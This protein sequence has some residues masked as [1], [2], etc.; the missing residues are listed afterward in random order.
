MM[1]GE[2]AASIVGVVGSLLGVALSYWI[3]RD[4]R[5][6]AADEVAHEDLGNLPHPRGRA[7]LR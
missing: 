6:F 2:L 5:K 4:Q 3:V 7:G 1:N